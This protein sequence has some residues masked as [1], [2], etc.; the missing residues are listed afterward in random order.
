MTY[1]IVYNLPTRTAT[2]HDIDRS[3]VPQYNVSSGTYDSALKAVIETAI[4]SDGSTVTLITPMTGEGAFKTVVMG[5]E[6]SALPL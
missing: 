5:A 3:E 2:R 4:L 1:V 6:T